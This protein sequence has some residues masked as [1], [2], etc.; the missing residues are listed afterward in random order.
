MARDVVVGSPVDE[1]ISRDDALVIDYIER[2]RAAW[3]E[4]APRHLAAGR[5][6][7][8][9]D[10]LRWGVW[11]IPESR[12]RLLAAVEPGADVVELGCGTAEIS[13]WLARHGARPVALDLAQRQVQNVES[14]QREFGI[15]FPVF[16]TNA[17]QIPYDDASFD[18]AISE[19]GASLWC[20]PQRWLA[21]AHRVLRPGGLLLFI[22]N[23]PLLMACTPANGGLAEDRLVRDYFIRRRLEF[24]QNG[25][26]EFHAT[27][28]EW[29]RLLRTSGF[30]I[31]DLIEVRA[32]GDAHARF[33]LTTVEWARRWP[34]EDVWIARRSD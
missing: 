3:E 19:Y 5:K 17:E 21:E 15:A 13:A 31:E 18:L 12:L 24:E 23:S 7:W 16:R 2:N 32:P 25:P 26:V 11:S 20:D 22:T 30:N 34:S 28:A 8:Q 27:H 29:V 33:A 9:E 1:V 14:L 10:E 6:A 4:W